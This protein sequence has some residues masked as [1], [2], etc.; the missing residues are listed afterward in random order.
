M[1]WVRLRDLKEMEKPASIAEQ[2]LASEN[3]SGSGW[4]TQFTVIARLDRAIQ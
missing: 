3:V 4:R 1:L 2:D